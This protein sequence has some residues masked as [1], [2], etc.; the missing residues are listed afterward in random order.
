[1]YETVWYFIRYSFLGSGLEYEQEATLVF[2]FYILLRIF[3][4]NHRRWFLF[5]VSLIISIFT[6]TFLSHLRFLFFNIQVTELFPKDVSQFK[7]FFAP[8]NFL[9]NDWSAI[10]LCFL[11]FLFVAVDFLKNVNFI[12]WLFIFV[13]VGI[14]TTFSRG[15]YLSLLLSNPSYYSCSSFYENHV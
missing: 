10:L 3:L 11:C 5:S 4:K 6:I 9:I 7:A 12:I 13:I 2:L 14:L 8:Y 15:A 1:M